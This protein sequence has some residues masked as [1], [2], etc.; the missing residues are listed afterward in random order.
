MET[1]QSK[2][3]SVE[4][5]EK[6]VVEINHTLQRRRSSVTEIQ[7]SQVPVWELRRTYTK[8]GKYVERVSFR[9]F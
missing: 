7:H 5:D 6:T 9:Q 3:L 8:H 1:P 2:E 4:H